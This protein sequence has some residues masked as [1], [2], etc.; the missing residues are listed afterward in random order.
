MP[1]KAIAPVMSCSKDTVTRALAADGPQYKLAPAGFDRDA[2]E[3]DPGTA[4]R[5]PRTPA[6]APARS[7]GFVARASL[8]EHASFA[9]I[10]PD[11]AD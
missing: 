11:V 4:S 10:H 9:A 8:R 1:I 5:E 6:M 7:G 3:P 2:V